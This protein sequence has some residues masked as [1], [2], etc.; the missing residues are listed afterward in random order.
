MSEPQ[1]ISFTERVAHILN[2][3][4]AFLSRFLLPQTLPFGHV[5]KCSAA[6]N[7]VT[8]SSV[9][10]CDAE[11]DLKLRLCMVASGS[12]LVQPKDGT[13]SVCS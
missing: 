8:L 13:F 5:E 12:V 6:L 9:M 10:P 3:E 11:L 7:P 2:N 4:S 1:C